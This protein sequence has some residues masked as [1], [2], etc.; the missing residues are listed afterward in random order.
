MRWIRY[1][2]P[3]GPFN[4]F[5]DDWMVSRKAAK[6][7][8]ASAVLELLSTL[9]FFGWIDI[10]KMT[11]SQ[12]LPWGILGM[13]GSVGTGFLWI[14]MWRYWFRLD[15]SGAWNK[16]FWFVVLLVGFWWGSCLYFF[17]AYLPRVTHHRTAE[18]GGHG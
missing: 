8:F 9:M 15:D 11:F 17:F 6:L 18:S 7:F 2:G 16:R 4:L 10:A 1:I 5:G 3:W 12:R 13:V 14:G